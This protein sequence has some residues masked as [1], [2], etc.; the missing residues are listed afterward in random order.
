MAPNDLRAAME[1]HGL[2]PERLINSDGE[3]DVGES[4]IQPLLY[5]LNED[6]FFGSLT[7]TAFRADRKA[8][9]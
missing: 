4:D 9:R 2:D 6:L 5:F 8:A 3:L 1:V 7:E